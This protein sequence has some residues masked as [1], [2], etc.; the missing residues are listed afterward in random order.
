MGKNVT[1]PVLQL[2]EAFYLQNFGGGGH[3][4]TQSSTP[5]KSAPV[6]CDK[7]YRDDLIWW[8]TILQKWIMLWYQLEMIS[9]FK[10]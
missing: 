4:S 2:L 8:M 9:N 7:N 5:P 3:F 10:L 6:Q 1:K